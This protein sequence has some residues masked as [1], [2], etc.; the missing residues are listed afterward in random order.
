MTKPCLTYTYGLRSNKS[1]LRPPFSVETRRLEVGETL[2]ILQ[3]AF[4]PE[5]L[6]LSPVLS[7]AM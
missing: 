3:H 6:R 2:P 4:Y 7:K 1:Q 5:M